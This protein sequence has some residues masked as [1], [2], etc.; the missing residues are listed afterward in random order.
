ML[1]FF[2]VKRLCGNVAREDAREDGSKMTKEVNL[3]M[4]IWSSTK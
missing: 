4:G 1:S 3:E 2:F